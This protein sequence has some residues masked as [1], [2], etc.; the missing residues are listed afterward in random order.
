MQL[1]HLKTHH[2]T[3]VRLANKKKVAEYF[4]KNPH[5]GTR[6][7]CSQALGLSYATVRV[8]VKELIEEN[9]AGA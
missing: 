1:E 2:M 7:G 5:D 4:R 8:L 6:K 3:K 9:E